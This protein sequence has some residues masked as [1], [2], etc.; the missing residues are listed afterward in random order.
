MK[1]DTHSQKDFAFTLSR[2][3]LYVVL[4]IRTPWLGV[5]VTYQHGQHAM[6]KTLALFS[7]A[8]AAVVGLDT[9]LRLNILPIVE[10]IYQTLKGWSGR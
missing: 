9:V 4:S 3:K 8:G 1:A 7:A 5:R 6:A 10:T 2:R